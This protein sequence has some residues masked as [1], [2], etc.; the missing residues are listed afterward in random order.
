MHFL[1]NITELTPF[2]V[3]FFWGLVFLLNSEKK[4]RPRFWLGIFMIVTSVV[5]FSHAVFFEGDIGLYLK[6]DWLYTLAGLSVFPIYYLYIRLLTR[7]THFQS[8]YLVHLIPAILLGLSLFALSSFA[9]PAQRQVYLNSAVVHYRRPGTEAALL[10]KGMALVFL[11]GRLIFAVQSLVYL[12]LGL[13]L[14]RKYNQRVANFYSNL[15]GKELVWV[16]ILIITLI[17]ASLT[18]FLVNIFGRNFFRQYQLLILPSAMFSVLFFLIGLV[19]NKQDYSISD[20]VLDENETETF[21]LEQN[22]D[23]QHLKKKLL[24]VMEK[25]QLFLDPNFRITILSSRLYT[26]RTYLSNLINTEFKMSFS[27]FINQYRVMYAKTLIAEDEQFRYSLNH[28]AEKSGFGSLSSFNR[29]FKQFEG[30]TAGSY[31]Q[32]LIRKIA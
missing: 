17:I 14:V 28:F 21:P 4:N 10:T 5:Y 19:G 29:A 25:E 24:D 13:Q 16:E 8:H 6:I 18:S 26:N 30:K 12:I 3:S 15:A 9:S 20:V 11:S 31:R 23:R 7:D 22:G 2:Y 32:H 27:D 1:K